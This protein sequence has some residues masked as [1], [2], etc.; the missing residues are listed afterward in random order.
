MI[1]VEMAQN[2][3]GIDLERVRESVERGG[4]S[5]R[6][7]S[8]REASY[9][10]ASDGTD[11]SGVSALPGVR[12]VNAVSCCYPLASRAVRPGSRPVEIAPG[13][14]LGEGDPVIMAG[15]CAVESRDQLLETA[16]AVRKAGARIL[17][18]GA[19]KPRSHPYAFQGLGSEGIAL[20]KEARKASGLPVIT[21]VMSPEEAEWVAPHVDILQ[22]GARNMQNFSLLKV[23]GRLDRPV[24][25]KRGMAATVEEWLQAAEYILAGGN[26]RVI[27]CERGIRSFDRNTRNTLDLGVIPLLKSLTHLPVVADPSHA[28]GR[29]DLVLPMSL[30]AIAAGADGLLVEVHCDPGAALCD[31]PQSL[32]PEEF[33][34][35]MTAAKRIMEAVRE[36]GTPW[37]RMLAR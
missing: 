9:I 31:G 16:L 12:K 14:V 23:L 28:T 22:V 32:D 25:L 29:R 37:Q 18:G 24:L 8:G 7:V 4:T 5:C 1:V 2:S 17:R 11:T 21:E 3:T 10:V 36:E 19:F 35:L 27:L 6:I 15:P 34:R 13:V 30:A 33:S 20:L 26:D